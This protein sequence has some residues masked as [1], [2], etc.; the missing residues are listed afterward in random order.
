[1]TIPQPPALEPD[2]AR[3]DA[4]GTLANAPVGEDMPPNSDIQGDLDSVVDTSLSDTLIERIQTA[5]DDERDADVRLVLDDLGIADRA[6]LLAKVSPDERAYLIEHFPDIFVAEVFSWMDEGLARSTLESM[7]PA[8]VAALFSDL[9]I[10]DALYLIDELSP[11]FQKEVLLRLSAS[12]RAAVEEGLNYPEASA[13]RL[14]SREFVSIPRFWTVGKTIDY[15]REASTELPDDFTVVFVIDPLYHVVGEIP[16]NRIL[17]SRRAIKIEELALEDIHPIPATMDQEDVARIFSREGLTSAPVVDDDSERLIGVITVDDVVDVIEEEAQEDILRLGG[18]GGSDL[19]SGLMSTSLSRFWWLAVN[20]ATAF[21]A[22]A[23][24]GAFEGTIEK[25]VAL[26]VLMPIVASMGGNAGTQTLTVVVRALAT[27]ELSKSNMMRMI[28]KET[29]VGLVNGIAFAVIT[30]IITALW[31][32]DPLLGGVIGLAMTI[33]LVAAG[34]FGIL[35]PL[36][37]ERMRL[38]PALASTVFLT[39]VTDVVGFFTFLGLA[40]WLM[41]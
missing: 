31:F 39:T 25:L 12:D 30:G 11:R 41:L 7:P 8:R 2:D 9:E 4:L 15:M 6:E 5:L 22:S 21:L 28:I 32:S 17:R 33:N 16:L 35:I 1:M 26:A 29:S 27:K 19:H 18:V 36:T 13:G 37:I 14:M 40:S 23:V 10:D 34:L 38:D 24:I 3:M 20:L